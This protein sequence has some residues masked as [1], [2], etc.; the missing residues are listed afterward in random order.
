MKQQIRLTEMKKQEKGV[1]VAIV[2]GGGMTRR[3]E[4]LGIRPGK[5][6]QKSSESFMRGPVTVRV[7][8]AQVAIGFGMASRILVELDRG[9]T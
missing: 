1:V 8:N 6:I 5:R 3:L 7:E 4:A 2:G 9:E